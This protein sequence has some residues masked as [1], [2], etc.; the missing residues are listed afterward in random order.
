MTVQEFLNTTDIDWHNVVLF[1]DLD[2]FQDTDLSKAEIY[3]DMRNIPDK[4]LHKHIDA[5]DIVIV[6]GNWLIVVLVEE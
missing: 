5:W 6:V 3:S 4:D 1:T 2:A